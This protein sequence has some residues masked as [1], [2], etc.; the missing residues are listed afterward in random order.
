M[1]HRVLIVLGVLSLAAAI[2][3]MWWCWWTGTTNPEPSPEGPLT[4]ESLAKTGTML[5]E[6]RPWYPPELVAV[7]DVRDR[8]PKS[9]PFGVPPVTCAATSPDGRWI[10]TSDQG[11]WVYGFLFEADIYLWDPKTLRAAAVLRMERTLPWLPRN[12]LV[13]DINAVT[14]RGLRALAFSP[15]G[16]LLAAGGHDDGT[17]QLWDLS[18]EPYRVRAT[19]KGLASAAKALLFHPDGQSLLTLDHGGTVRA[20]TK[21]EGQPTEAPAPVKLTGVTAMAYAAD[22]KTLALGDTA[23]HLHYYRHEGGHWAEKADLQLPP[24]NSKGPVYAVAFAPDGGSF[25]AAAFNTPASVWSTDATPPRLLTH[26]GTLKG[27]Y[28]YYGLFFSQ[29]GSQ[30]VTL[31]SDEPRVWQRKGDQFTERFPGPHPFAGLFKFT[32]GALSTDGE[33]LVLFDD[34]FQRLTAWDIRGSQPVKRAKLFH[35]CHAIQGV[36]FA[37]GGRSLFVHESG[38]ISRWDLVKNGFKEATFYP[39]GALAP[40]C[41]SLV[42]SE[43][44][45]MVR[46]EID[47]DDLR[48]EPGGGGLKKTLVVPNL[49][50]RDVVFSPDGRFVAA[51]HTVRDLTPGKKAEFFAD[52]KVSPLAFTPD[53]KTLAVRSGGTVQLW[54]VGAGKPQLLRSWKVD[55]PIPTRAAFGADGQSLVL[56]GEDGIVRRWDLTQD[57]PRSTAFAKKHTDAIHAVTFAPGETKLATAGDDGRVVV[58]TPQGEVLKE[59]QLSGPIYDVSFAPDGRHLATAN[60]EG[61][62]F[63]LRLP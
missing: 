51:G 1:R 55:P 24:E 6:A 46:Y 9:V 14:R 21:L 38:R 18:H 35:N 59:W 22:G 29:D 12:G 17:V 10:A 62:V 39:D 26:L 47:G 54:E 63:V 7:L 37:P 19:I 8:F 30:L 42:K 40:N 58:W 34:L 50:F 52:D 33:T 48:E 45:G 32:V 16:K 2:G 4:L 11:T 61:T 23:G 49:Q 20:W 44:Y 36:R 3:I 60:A 43:V 15:D 25:A 28:Y 41:E 57:P 13:V 53:G 5:P 56:V 27:N 31:S